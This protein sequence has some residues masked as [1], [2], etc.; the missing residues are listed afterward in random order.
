MNVAAGFALMLITWARG[1]QL[2]RRGKGYQVALQLLHELHH[3]LQCCWQCPV[4]RR[5]AC[6]E[7]LQPYMRSGWYG[8]FAGG[9]GIPTSMWHF[10]WYTC[11][12][13][14]HICHTPLSGH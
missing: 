4:S 1:G 14:L 12:G 9:L 3:H 8:G 5:P 10:D 11:Q 6:Y 13:M 7:I 2:G